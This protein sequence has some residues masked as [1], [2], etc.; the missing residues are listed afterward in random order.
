[1]KAAYYP[2]VG[3]EQLVPDQFWIEAEC[4]YDIAT[5]YGISHWWFQRQ[6]F[7]IDQFSSEGDRQAVRTHMRILSVVRIEVFSMYGYNYM[8]E[9]KSLLLADHKEYVISRKY[10][11]KGTSKYNVGSEESSE[12]FMK[13]T[14][15]VIGTLQQLMNVLD[16]RVNRIPDQQRTGKYGDF[17][18]YTSDDLIHILE[19]CRRFFLSINLPDHSTNVFGF[20]SLLKPDL[21]Y[22]APMIIKGCLAVM[23]MSG[24]GGDHSWIW[25][26]REYNNIASWTKA[27]DISEGML[28]NEDHKDFISYNHE[29]RTRSRL[30]VDSYYTF[31]M[32]MCIDS[33]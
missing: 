23:F 22:Y 32:D 17:D 5:M 8:K 1:M 21:Q 19:S 9:D 3:L 10:K 2:D 28:M 29:T 31:D 33:L 26:M 15:L 20:I 14:R 6:R 30:I 12:R 7:Y 24:Y 27:F 13:Y 25:V 11:L 18:G 4:K 16:Y